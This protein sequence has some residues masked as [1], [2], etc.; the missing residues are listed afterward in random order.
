M[1]PDDAKR[2]LN[3]YGPDVATLKGKMAKKQNSGIPNYQATPLPA[4]IIAQ[5][6][7]VR[8][9]I[10]IFWV[11]S[12]PCFHTISEWIKFCTVAAIKNRTRRT[13]HMETQVII[14]MYEARGFNVTRVVEDQ[15]F[16]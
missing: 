8:L 7:N 4:P 16:L 3:I 2:A 6:N 13:L 1:T 5:Y 10:D 14:N 15:E 12:S 9:F 11:N